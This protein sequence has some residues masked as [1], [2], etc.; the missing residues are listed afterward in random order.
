MLTGLRASTTGVYTNKDDWRQNPHSRDAIT[1]PDCF[2]SAGY[3]TK[4]GGKIYHAHSLNEEAFTGFL[5]PEPWDEFFPS[6]ARQMPPEVEPN[7]WPVNS[8]KK[9]YKGKFDWAP[10]QTEDDE[11]ADGKVV[12]WAEQLLATEHSKPVISRSRNLSASHPLVDA[13]KIFRHASLGY[14]RIAGNC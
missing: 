5:D 14:D 13:G 6:K 8:E 12:R 10:L 4:G 11:M 3:T 9:F 2:R 7:E 1:I